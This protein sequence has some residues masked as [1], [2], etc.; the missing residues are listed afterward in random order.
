VTIQRGT[1]PT[2]SSVADAPGRK[3]KVK[4]VDC[5]V[6]PQ[7][8]SE[9]DLARFLPEKWKHI[10]RR[11]PP[12]P[13]RIDMTNGAR[14]VDSYPPDGGPPGSDPSFMDEQLLGDAKVDIAI[15][16][17]IEAGPMMDPVADAMRHAAVNDW[18]AEK[19]LTDGNAHGRYRGSIRVPLHNP[20]AAV[21]EIQRWADDPRFVQVL[22]FPTYP[23]GFGHPQYEP[24]W[25]AAA[26][27]GL[28]IGSHPSNS[29]VGANTTMFS[30]PVGA[31][32]FF[33]DWHSVGYPSAY[34]GHLASM[35][36]SGVFARYPDLKIVVIEAG[37]S[38]SLALSDH[39]D[40]N[41]R[42]IRADVPEL[43]EL[44][45]FYMNRNVLFSSQPI[46]EP[47]P[48]T[49]RFSYEQLQAEHR[50]VFSTDYPHWDF[51][52]PARALHP[53]PKE[54]RSR[55][56]GETARELYGLPDERW[57]PETAGAATA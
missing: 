6:H 17:P 52:D 25:R 31:G 49:L 4:I 8:S 43:T 15:L 34:I 28:P 37:V 54:L 1:S 9:E 2:S 22:A 11:D 24:I 45:S 38:W 10:A 44:P 47:D 29:G 32:S 30:S 36:C 20:E 16:V 13:W 19:W 7:V 5:D 55:I 27:C 18:L 23:L 46:E 35:I 21:K 14:R 57:E 56:L 33:F 51:D 48:E 50:V 3:V 39:L 40:R 41:W 26:E 53:L 12:L 42:R